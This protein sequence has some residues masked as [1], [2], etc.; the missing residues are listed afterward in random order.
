MSEYLIY[1]AR[2]IYKSCDLEIEPNWHL[3]FLLLKK[4]KHL[5]VTE[6]AQELN[7]SHPAIIK[8]VKMMKQKGYI[9]SITDTKDSRRQL[10]ELT[11]KSIKALPTLEVTWNKIHRAIR[12]IV[13]PDL[14]SKLAETEEKLS[15]KGL[16]ERYQDLDPA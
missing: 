1:D 6:I 16:F 9:R 10:L 2:K 8:I 14:L 13:E 11:D 7:F 3:I 12:E 4:E 5:T 15:N